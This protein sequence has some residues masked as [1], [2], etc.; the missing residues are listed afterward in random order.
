VTNCTFIK[1]ENTAA[2]DLLGKTG[3]E[4][5]AGLIKVWPDLIGVL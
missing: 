5:Q 1:A 3:I 4:D 2:A